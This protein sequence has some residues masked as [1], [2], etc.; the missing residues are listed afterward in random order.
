MWMQLSDTNDELPATLYY[1]RLLDHQQWL[2][3]DD[4]N[5]PSWQ[6]LCED[7]EFDE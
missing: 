6:V 2:L 4:L 5:H 7:G 1:D 3:D